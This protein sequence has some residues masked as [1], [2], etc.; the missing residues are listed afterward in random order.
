MNLE[1]YQA[2][3]APLLFEGA[4]ALI[5]TTFLKDTGPAA[6]QINLTGGAPA[7]SK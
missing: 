4:L 5:L 6:S 1:H 3:F 7:R 2:G